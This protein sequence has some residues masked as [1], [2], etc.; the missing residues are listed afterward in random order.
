MKINNQKN[1]LIVFVITFF[2]TTKSDAM[3]RPTKPIKQLLDA[4][5]DNN[6][7]FIRSLIEKQIDINT[8]GYGG[9]TALHIATKYNKLESIALLLAEPNTDCNVLNVRGLSAAMIAAAEPSQEAWDLFL[10]SRKFID[11]DVRND[12]EMNAYDI[13]NHHKKKLP[14]SLLQQKE[15]ERFYQSNSTQNQQSATQSVGELLPNSTTEQ[16]ISLPLRIVIIDDYWQ[17]PAGSEWILVNSLIH[18]GPS[19]PV[20]DQI[21]TITPE[22]LLYQI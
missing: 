5:Q 6:T 11:P 2:I 4:A 20:F 3:I 1:A 19:E 7:N 10:L 17:T 18:E 12:E 22:P 9:N 14:E 15:I 16:P 21:I 8:K 13:A